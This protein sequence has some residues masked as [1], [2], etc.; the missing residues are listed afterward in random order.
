ML[1]LATAAARGDHASGGC[2]C[3]ELPVGHIYGV[4]IRCSIFL[5]FYALYSTA[6]MAAAHFP[7][8]VILCIVV[9]SLMLLV[10][11][12]LVHE[13]GHGLTAKR[14]GGSISYILLW[15]LGGL[16]VH[17]MPPHGPKRE[18]LFNDWWVTFNGPCTH[19]V[20]TPVWAG[21]C[22]L[23]FLAFGMK[24]SWSDLWRDLNPLDHASSL[25][26]HPEA[27]ER[28]WGA[29][30]LLQL[31]ATAVSLNVLL[32]LFNL[33]FPMYPM[34]S[35]KLLVTGMQL[36]GTPAERAARRFIWISGACVVA[37][38]GL[39]ACQVYR[40]IEHAQQQDYHHAVRMIGMG[41]VPIP[42][43]IM[44]TTGLA[45]WGGKQTWDLHQLAEK[46][47]LH[48][49]PLFSHVDSASRT[50]RDIANGRPDTFVE[51]RTDRYDGDDP[52]P[53]PEPPYGG[54]T[55]GAVRIV[56]GRIVR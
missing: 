36:C 46:K 11:T 1:R 19:L 16:C 48:K 21:L 52:P 39:V 35:S 27:A 20:M 54:R 43:P 50:V 22:A 18:K 5:L 3:N 4:P 29:V 23:L 40:W 51:E 53:P 9:G 7:W 55:Y 49:H 32:F 44:L 2:N 15:P 17:T 26:K 45:F 12:I 8:W 24:Y 25:T 38:L 56:D 28:G 37:L 47:H 34:D 10:V 33:L 13:F 14:F 41:L 6:G 42:F 31:C 30:I